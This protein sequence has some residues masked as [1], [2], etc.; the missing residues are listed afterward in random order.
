MI[1]IENNKNKYIVYIISFIAIVQT[2]VLQDLIFFNENITLFNGDHAA[3]SSVYFTL[4][5]LLTINFY[6]VFKSI[7]FI[8]RTNKNKKNKLRTL[9]NK[10][11][12][13]YRFQ[14][15]KLSLLRLP[16]IISFSLFFTFSILI[17][18]TLTIY[19]SNAYFNYTFV[20]FFEINT[21]LFL[22]LTWL[23]FAL[24]SYL[25]FM[26]S[27]YKFICILIIYSFLIIAFKSNYGLFNGSEIFLPVNEQVIQEL[28]QEDIFK[29]ID[30]S[31][32]RFEDLR[33]KRLDEIKKD[34]K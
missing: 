13:K 25:S 26:Q 22:F 12:R 16:F 34:L 5:F 10:R 6:K 27:N 1:N 30:K 33:I 11:I 3:L 8:I 32:D 21:P 23:I 31:F 15:A 19:N 24:I 2:F 28:K 14:I 7:R 4:C 20:S 29:N 9:S 18:S 17:Q